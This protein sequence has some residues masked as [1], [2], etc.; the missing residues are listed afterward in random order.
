VEKDEIWS[1]ALEEN[2]IQSGAAE[3]RVRR[4]RLEGMKSMDG[5]M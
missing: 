1:G 3:R 2:E 5:H 4:W